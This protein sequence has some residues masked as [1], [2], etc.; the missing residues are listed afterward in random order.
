MIDKMMTFKR[1]MTLKSLSVVVICVICLSINLGAQAFLQ[2]PIAGRYLNDFIIV[3]Y[4]DWSIESAKF[5]HKCGSKTYNGHQGTDFVIRSFATMDS[6]VAVIAAASG[7]VIFAKDDLFDRE[8]LSDT[9]KGFGNYI[10]LSHD[11]K[12]QTYYAHIKKGSSKIKLGDFVKEGDTLAFVGSSGNSSDPHLH[13]ELWYDSTYVVD[14]FKG[15]CGNSGS[16]WLNPIVYDTSFSIWNTGLIGFKP[17]LDTLREEPS[18]KDVFKYGEDEAITYWNISYGVRKYDIFKLRWITPNGQEW[19][20]SDYTANQDYW[21]FYYWDYIDV[22]L[23]SDEGI[24]TVE[25]LLNGKKIDKNTFRINRSS[26]TQRTSNSSNIKIYPNPVIDKFTI[27]FEDRHFAHQNDVKYQ[28]F[29]SLGQTIMEGLLS[30]CY[31]NCEISTKNLQA[32]LYM[33]EIFNHDQRISTHI[34]SI[35]KP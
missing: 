23:M 10:A 9:S 5:D 7:T 3:N 2:T 12:Y 32:G 8:K 18:F 4:V 11:N 28:I 13:F 30:Q 1:L 17:N 34:I 14:P 35:N 22:P 33:L 15:I 26:S 29:I 27:H 16:L 21:Y 19:F 6:G 20:S 24:W 25:L 31:P